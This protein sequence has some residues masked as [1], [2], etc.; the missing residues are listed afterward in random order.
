MVPVTPPK[1][2]DQMSEAELDQFVDR[3]WDQTIAPALDAGAIVAPR[4]GSDGLRG[5]AARPPR[6][7]ARAS[8]KEKRTR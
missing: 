3:M 7:N 5:P 8:G 6:P 4:V 1:P 2:L